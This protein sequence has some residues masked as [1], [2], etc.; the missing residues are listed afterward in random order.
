ME[1]LEALLTPNL[2]NC[3]S[4]LLPNLAGLPFLNTL[5]AAFAESGNAT[6]ASAGQGGAAAAGLSAMR[7]LLSVTGQPATQA[8][9]QMAALDAHA[10]SASSLL[11]MAGPAANAA[12]LPDKDALLQAVQAQGLRFEQNVGQENAQVDFT[13]QG[14]GYTV[15]LTPDGYQM[16]F[17]TGAGEAAASYGYVDMHLVG[18]NANA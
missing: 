1:A 9:G 11:G 16:A 7:N 12:P 4:A 10:N 17:R 6:P 13:A 3:I 2:L 8:A 14:P 15:F 5:A 18:A